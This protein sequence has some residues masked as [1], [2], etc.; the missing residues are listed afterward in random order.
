MKR[1]LFIILIILVL[2]LLYQSTPTEI[3]KLKVF[4]YLV[5]KQQ[6]SG[7]FTI[8]NITEEDIAN[9]GGWPLP[10]ERLGQIHTEIIAKGAIGVGYVIGFPQPDRMGGDAYLAES[11]KYGT[12]VLA[13]FENPNGNYPPTTGTVI[14]GDDIQQACRQFLCL[15]LW[16]AHAVFEV[17]S[18][19]PLKLWY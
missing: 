4:D 2:P 14:L 3:L 10:R 12:S 13:M 7:Y 17:A 8:L 9:E 15:L 18:L 19:P 6:P 11:L 16:Q 1:P 5:P